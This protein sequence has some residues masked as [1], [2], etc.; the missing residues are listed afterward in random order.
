MS[1]HNPRARI[2]IGEETLS[3]AHKRRPPQ[4]DEGAFTLFDSF[5]NTSFFAGV[6]VELT[7]GKASQAEFKVLDEDF[8]FIDSYTRSDGVMPCAA[9][10]YLGYGEELGE[11]VFEGLLS[12]VEH[13]DGESTFCFYDRS[14]R[15]KLEEKTEHHKGMDIA[16]MKKLVERNSLNFELADKSI[17]GLPLRATKQEMQTDWDFLMSLAQHAGLVV[18]VRGN[19]LY[20]ARPAHVGE[21]VLTLK[22]RDVL[23]LKGEQLR[24]EMPE[25]VD[26]SP[27]SVEVRVRGR[28]GRRVSGYSAKRKRGRTKIVY[29]SLRTHSAPSSEAQRRAQAIKDLES[30]PSFTCQV[31]T[32]F[33]PDTRIVGTRDTVWLENR[34]EL[35]SGLYLVDSVHMNFSPGELTLDFDLVRDALSCKELMQ[36]PN[37]ESVYPDAYK[38]CKES[39][40]RR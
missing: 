33:Y 5:T 20:V 27:A 22:Q 25:N 16:V 26:G 7:T 4:I 17:K 30:E 9:Y 34:G 29:H 36:I 37:A 32:L 40:Q 38:R 12:A 6:S 39:S 1:I 31:K 14:L 15:M 28:G 10:V 24:Y 19:T 21:P 2:L 35:F 23:A 13:N 18:W 11:P 3:Q 8:S